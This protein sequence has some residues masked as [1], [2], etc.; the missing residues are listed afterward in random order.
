MSEQTETKITIRDYRRNDWVDICR[1]HDLAR[2]EELQGSC[3]PRAFVPIEKDPEVEDLKGCRKF[4]ACDEDKVVGFVGIDGSSLSWLYVDPT[5]QG[6]GIGSQLLKLAV[7]K[8]G[9]KIWTIVLAGNV[10]ARRL[11]ERFGF[12]EQSRYESSNAGYPCTCLHLAL[13]D[14]KPTSKNDEPEPDYYQN[15]NGRV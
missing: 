8:I 12:V 6:Q 7:D 13:M 4:V 3:D 9:P 2:P 14:E 15:G 10:R 11:Y 1:I 5:Y